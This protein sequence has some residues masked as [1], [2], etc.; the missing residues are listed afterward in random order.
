MCPRARSPRRE[1]ADL[2]FVD[3]R[4]IIDEIGGT[5]LC[6]FFWNQGE[7]L[8]NK[9]LSRMIAYAKDRDILTMVSTNASFL[10]TSAAGELI[11]AGLDQ[12]IVSL[13]GCTP[14]VYSRYRQGGDFDVVVDNVKNLILEKKRRRSVRP[15][16]ELQF[17]VMRDNEHEVDAVRALGRDLGVDGV[18][19]KN[20]E[21]PLAEVRE[22]LFPRDQ[23][24]VLDV[25]KGGGKHPCF[26]PWY[27]SLINSDGTV[28]A[29][30]HD[31]FSGHAFGNALESPF[32]DIWKSHGYQEF[33][34]KVLAGGVDICAECPAANFNGDFRISGRDIR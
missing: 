31:F 4:K 9:D 23:N 28:L 11:A 33:R 27:S 19:L 20:I 3:Y 34:N 18:S 26:R 13:D 29:C 10:G 14:E 12:L 21:M 1:A 17:L 2:S 22:G 25:Y 24:F 32:P 30:C 6:V 15:F 8:L 16:V 7:P 5:L